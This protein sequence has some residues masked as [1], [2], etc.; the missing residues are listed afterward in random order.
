MTRLERRPR[1]DI[2]VPMSAAEELQARLAM[3]PVLEP[4]AVSVKARARPKEA[5]P[6]APAGEEC[7]V[8]ASGEGCEIVVPVERG[9]GR[10][11]RGSRDL[12]RSSDPAGCGGLGR[13]RLAALTM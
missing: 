4:V 2:H 8:V 1:T 7:A 5:C 12:A 3:L 10:S 6:V 11:V 9:T 13:Y